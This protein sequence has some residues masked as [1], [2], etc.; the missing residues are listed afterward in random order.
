MGR[1]IRIL[2]CNC[3]FWSK[4]AFSFFIA[5]A[6]LLFFAV[7]VYDLRQIALA[8][9]RR[10]QL[11]L[12]RNDTATPIPIPTNADGS[13][14]RECYH[15]DTRLARLEPDSSRIMMGFHLNWAY[16]N[17]TAITNRLGKVAPAVINAFMKID[18]SKTVPFDFDSLRWHGY[19][20]QKVRGI[21]ELTLEPISDIAGIPD[22]LY[23]QIAREIRD[24]NTQK[25]VP[26]M[27]RYGHE[28]NGDWVLAYGYRP[29]AYKTSFRKMATAIRKYT[30][31]T[32]MVWA[33]NVGTQYPFSAA[34]GDI[35]APK[36]VRGT[37]EFRELDT[38]NNGVIAAGDDPYLPFYPGDEFV[39][40]VGL[41]IYFYPQSNND[42]DLGRP[43]LNTEV[44]SPTYLREQ[45]NLENFENLVSIPRGT[46]TEQFR[47]MMNF[48]ERFCKERNKPMMI[49][50]TGAPFFLVD[51]KIQLVPER[52]GE[53]AIKK[54][55]WAQVWSRETAAMWP[56]LKLA[57]QFEESKW[58][59]EKFQNWAVTNASSLQV[60]PEFNRFVETE[61]GN[62]IMARDMG[63]KCDGSVVLK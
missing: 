50:E 42:L 58:Q 24:I 10:S 18:M 4:A 12:Q 43:Y 40:W 11:N 32:A 6:G 13:V 33:P 35:S 55:W 9:Q 37:E 22:E 63:F 7:R 25:G 14:S 31:M 54:A 44:P 23:D 49:P 53:L 2:F 3:L 17:P 46:T 20:V 48:Y 57:V 27:L 15:D 29:I 62:I 28:M 16:D 36:P 38:D 5:T 21:F 34:P 41:S 51:D 59:H 47:A 39:D 61:R 8:N 45:M 1:P 19:E 60:L 26:V 56:R 30:N 52:A